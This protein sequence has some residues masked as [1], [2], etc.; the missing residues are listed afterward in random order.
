MGISVWDKL[1]EDFSSEMLIIYVS[2]YGNKRNY[3]NVL[4]EDHSVVTPRVIPS[5]GDRW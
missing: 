1:A 5:K 4:R 3:S 2:I